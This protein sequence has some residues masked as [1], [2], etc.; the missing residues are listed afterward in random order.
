MQV[1]DSQDV[2]D[3][4]NPSVYWT[5]QGA[6]SVELASDADKSIVPSS[7]EI[8]DDIVY[9]SDG[10]IKQ[11]KGGIQFYSIRSPF[12]WRYSDIKVIRDENGDLLWVNDRYR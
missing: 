1:K 6:F 5:H 10:F 12:H 9:V 2:K 8:K 4:K 11:T 7:A 3:F